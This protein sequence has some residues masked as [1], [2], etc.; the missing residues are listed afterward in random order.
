MGS[1]SKSIIQFSLDLM[2]NIRSTERDKNTS[3]SPLSISATLCLLL[4]GSNEDTARQIEQCLHLPESQMQLKDERRGFGK[5]CGNKMKKEE[6]ADVHSQFRELLY[7]LNSPK[8]GSVLTIAN[9]AFTQMNFPLSK[10]YLRNA[11]DFYQAKV[12]TVDFQDDKARQQI[13]SWVEEKTQGKITNLLSENSLDISTSLILINATYFKGFWKSKFKE[14]NTTT[15]P[16]YTSKD[17][18]ILVPMM[19]QNAKFNLGIIEEI[20][21]QIIEL[22]YETEDLCMCIILP[23][24]VDG[25]QKMEKQIT[26]ESVLKWTDP[27][28]LT[29]TRLELQ[30]PRFQI[31]MNYDLSQNLMNMG[32]VD[33]FS[34]QK[35]NLSG[36][37]E[38]GLYLSKVVHK[39][40]IEI[41]EEGTEAAAGTAAV[42]IPKSLNI[43]KVDHPFVC[44]I[45]HKDTILFHTMVYS[46]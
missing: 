18:E 12:E 7:K 43:F 28:F 35:A 45:K 37:S 5:L 23:N 8:T 21:A 41:N 9:A 33:A 15:A 1:I 3:I 40:F 36:I 32:M 38:I 11:E 30:L 20:E 39:C 31:E 17:S 29:S 22:P 34:Q 42:I 13:N 10:D 26:A 19:R 2:S 25:L 14:E 4:L 27:G 6:V 44:F 16:F 46:P 24:E